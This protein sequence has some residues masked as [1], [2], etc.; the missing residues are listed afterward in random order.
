MMTTPEKPE[1]NLLLPTSPKKAPTPASAVSAFLLTLPL[2]TV[3]FAADND[4]ELETI[5]VEA[6]RLDAPSPDKLPASSSNKFTAPLRDTPKTVTI[7]PQKILQDTQAKTLEEALR[8]TPGITF[9]A[10]EGGNPMGDRPFIRGVDSQN[11][12]NVDG[13]RDIAAGT[14]ATFNTEQI[15]VIKGADSAMNGRGGGGGSILIETKKPKNEDFLNADLGWGTDQHYSG[16]IDANKAFGNGIAVRVNGMGLNEKIPGRDGPKNRRWG[17]APSIA[18]GLGT[19]TRASLGWYHYQTDDIP[20]SGLPFYRDSNRN[21]ILPGTVLHPTDGG[22]RHNW[23]GLYNR[24]Y[25][26]EKTD[27]GTF[28]FEHDFSEAAKLRNTMRYGKSTQKYMLTQPDDSQGNTSK[29]MVFRRANFRDSDTTTWQNV[30]ELTG[31]FDTGPLKHSYNAG[32]EL[33]HE[34]ADVKSGAWQ[35]GNCNKGIGAISNFWCTSLTHPTPHDPWPYTHDFGSATH[36]KTTTVSAYAFDTVE[37]SPQWFINGGLR[38]DHYKTKV[39]TPASSRG[40]AGHYSRNDNLWN[41]QVGLVFK[42][43]ENG[44]IYANYSTSSKP[45]GSF[46]GQGSEDGSITSTVGENLKPE[47]TRAYEVG[48]KWDLLDQRLGLTASVFRNEITNSRITDGSGNMVMDGKKHVNGLELGATGHLTDVWDVFAGYTY[49]KGEYDDAGF[50]TDR[51]S[52]KVTGKSVSSG[53]DLF[54]TPRHS[55]TLWST[56]RVLPKLQIGG[57]LIAMSK[58]IGGYNWATNSKG[59]NI[60]VYSQEVPGY[61]RFDAMA[62]YDFNKNMALQLN[63]YNLTN[64]KYYSTAYVTH[65]AL[66]G[67]GR[68]ALATFKLSY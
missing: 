53:R 42:P 33:S 45:G 59:A 54:N 31:K 17:L 11:S 64:K 35:G 25:R 65:Y 6:N 61:T 58:R 38:Y 47:K 67:A 3:A 10:G 49:M 68:S 2:T 57:G 26:K 43:L 37:L 46:L 36:Y 52:G 56:Y 27:Q 18:F 44:S 55:F 24:D 21:N 41:Y 32:I 14:R 50:N 29:G 34:K 12:I 30:T 66:P 5:K 4:T 15:E 7:I 60:G 13:L 19:A 8:T 23:Y 1:K 48:T 9:G 63:V 62:R 20:D 39:D 16:T 51:R 40:A 28:I 22:N